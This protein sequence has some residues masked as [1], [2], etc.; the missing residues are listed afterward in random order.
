M[1]ELVGRK[2][3]GKGET[4]HGFYNS[5]RK[6]R[7]RVDT[8]KTK[9]CQLWENIRNRCQ[10]LPKIDEGKYGKYVEC[11]ACDEWLDFQKFAEWFESVQFYKRGWQLDKDLLVKNNKMYS[12]ETCVFLPE[13]INKALNT[14][15][16]E[17]GELPLGLSW[18][19]P[20]KQR[21]N[22]Q[23]DCKNSEFSLRRTMAK[24]QIEEAFTLYKQHR[25]GYIKFLAGKYKDELD[26]R[27]YDALMSY[28]ITMED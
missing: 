26:P 23:Y 17:R 1:T 2:P 3:F 14:K 21:I 7:T 9:A 5:G 6:Y 10:L 16:R 19:T 8:V 15:S 12:P 27:A 25:E 4:K 11:F 18:L 22:L 20:E 28:E 13:E 24:D